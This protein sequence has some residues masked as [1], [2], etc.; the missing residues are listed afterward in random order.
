VEKRQEPNTGYAIYR[1]LYPLMSLFGDTW[2]IK[3][4]ELGEAIFRTGI[5]GADKETLENAEIL[6]LV[7]SHS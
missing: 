2:S 7:Q 4:T 6:K 3:S 1:A 5:H